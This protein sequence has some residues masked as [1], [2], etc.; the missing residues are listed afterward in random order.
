MNGINLKI[1]LRNILRNKVLS[2]ISILGLGIGLGSI[3]LLLA[4]ITHERS[5]EKCI[6]DYK[7]VYK[8]LLGDNCMTPYPLGE[9]MKKDFPEVKSFFRINQANNIQVRNVKNE[10]GRN[11][12]FAFAD[13]SIFRILGIRFI[14]GAP[15]IARNEVAISRKEAEKYFGN[16]SPLGE[17]LKVKLNDEF[18]NMSVSGVYRDFP[19][20]STLYPDFIADVKLSEVLFG[21]FKSTLGQYGS[22]ISTVLNWDMTSFYTYL[23]LDKNADRSSVISKMQGY[24]EFSTAKDWIRK[25][26]YDLQ[27]V[28]EIYLK[29]DKFLGSFQFFRTGNAL[30]H[31]YYWAISLLILLISVTNYI[32]LTRASAA[33]RLHEL[34]TRKFVGANPANLRRQLIFEANIITILSLIPASFVINYGMTLVNQTLNK[35]L[36]SYVFSSPVMWLYLA[37]VVLFTGTISGII[38]GSS[39]SRIST[40]LLLSGKTS[41][42]SVPRRWDYAFLVFH[43]SLFIIL[44]SGV[45]VIARQIRYSITSIKGLNPKNILISELNSNKLRSAFS[46][47]RS[48][49]SKMPGVVSVAGSSF[50][51]LYSPYLPITLA[52]PDGEKVTFE[53]SVMG[54]GMPE[55]L[56]IEIIEGSSFKTYHQSPLE[57]LFNESSAKKY[58]IK[59]GDNFLKVFH[60]LGIVRDFNSHSSHTA[61]NPM[62]ILQQHPDKMGLLAIKTDGSNDRDIVQKLS[63]LYNETDPN[64]IF[65]V[66]HYSD[67]INGLYT[68]EENQARIMG[69]FSLLAICLAVMGLFG[70][71]FISIA[72]RKKEIGIRKIHGGSILEVMLLL[73]RG[74]AGWIIVSIIISIPVSIYLMSKWEENFA[75]R[76]K[77]SWWLFAISA[78]AAVIITLLTVS[79][80]IWKA[81]SGN[82]VNA[83]RYE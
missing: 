70:M 46:M 9:A 2:L 79:W 41:E 21:Q 40:L 11:Q 43:F 56:N 10:F 50:I 57:V 60:V 53:G 32:F 5:F 29:S 72:K 61:I 27:P 67:S 36:S 14:S 75:Y 19:S 16:L 37:M 73:G 26:N 71:A 3:I 4:L 25:R 48:E 20:N 7:N 44:S 13:S 54:E 62:V 51:P 45:L 80:Q 63:E 42:K 82:P 59:V 55:L 33:S 39:V 35:N 76:S 83:L 6:P 18:I 12:E 58:N 81:A 28:T 34:G 17:I 49:I 1:A 15:A 31:K 64:E 74:I 78:C 77:L 52:N 66:I 24:K 22:G 69:A 23:V 68:R 47:F 30:D 65:D 38:I 8:V